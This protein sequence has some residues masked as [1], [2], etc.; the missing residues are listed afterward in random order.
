MTKIKLTP[1]IKNTSGNVAVTFALLSVPLLGA[2]GVAFDYARVSSERSKVLESMD[3]ALLAGAQQTQRLLADGQSQQSAIEG[4]KIVALDYYNVSM[5]DRNISQAN[6]IEPVIT[7]TSDQVVANA[8]FT[9]Q[10]DATLSSVLGISEGEFAVESTVAVSS[11]QFLQFHFVIDNSNSM[12]IGA[13]DSDIATMQNSQ[14]SC[15]FACHVPS[16]ANTFTD[17]LDDARALGVTLRMDVVRDA[18]DSVLE[19]IEEQN[20]GVQVKAAVYTFSNDLVVERDVTENITMARNSAQTIELA[21]DWGTGGT[22]PEYV[23]QKL[24][25]KIGVSGDGSSEALAKRVIVFITDGV[26][27]NAMFDRNTPDDVKADPNHKTFN[28]TYNGAPGDA[29]SFKGFNSNACSDLKNF[30]KADIYTINVEYITPKVGEIDDRFTNIENNL[31][32]Q[33]VDNLKACATGSDYFFKA[34]TPDQINA[35]FDQLIGNAFR[36]NLQLTQ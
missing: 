30:N 6:A 29:Y 10:I 11:P 34:K 23:L 7:V 36:R 14:M 20:M 28:P 8:S 26:A 5:F 24:E 32:P 35:S 13:T 17:T 12:G 16:G 27:S 9:G 15:A 4:G 2:A 31:K 25:N 21:G 1:F 19:R 33:I 18:V 3:A 22:S